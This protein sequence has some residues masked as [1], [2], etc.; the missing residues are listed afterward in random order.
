[1]KIFLRKSKSK[2]VG[3]ALVL[4]LVFLAVVL[5]IFASIFYWAG[6][7]AKMTLRNNQYNMSQ[8]AAEAATEDVMGWLI[9]DFNGRSIDT[10]NNYYAYEPGTNID[11]ST[12][13][14]QYQFSDTNGNTGRISVSIGSL[15]SS[16]VP[17][18]SQYGGLSGYA[19]PVTLI[20]RATPTNA[21][22]TM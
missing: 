5:M 10:T 3:F 8:A 4:T 14:V 22:Q 21:A 12:W 7:G 9:R 6:S 11:Q 2:I 19:Q 13:P 20:A 15:S 18:N 16:L 1:M 17:L